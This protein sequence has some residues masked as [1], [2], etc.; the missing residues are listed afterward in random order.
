V[1]F[2][3]FQ[4]DVFTDTPFSGNPAAVC[5]VTEPRDDQWMQHVAREMNL[6]ETA[7][8]SQQDNLFHLRWFTPLVEGEKEPP[9][10][11]GFFSRRTASSPCSGEE[12]V[13][14]WARDHSLPRGTPRMSLPLS[15]VTGRDG[16]RLQKW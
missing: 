9:C 7:F 8:V 3:L 15:H 6:S 4:A 16:L 12:R 11:S 1:S 14:Q 10:L 13:P 2:P 5:L